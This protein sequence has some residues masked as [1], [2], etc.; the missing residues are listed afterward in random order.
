MQTYK[1]QR[2]IDDNAC[3]Y[4]LKSGGNFVHAVILV[5]DFAIFQNNQ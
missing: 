5:D 4:I 2:E 3:L 1:K